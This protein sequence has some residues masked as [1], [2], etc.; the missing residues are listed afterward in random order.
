M[1]VTHLIAKKK[2]KIKKNSGKLQCGTRQKKF[3]FQIFKNTESLI[4]VILNETIWTNMLLLFSL[5]MCVNFLIHDLLCNSSTLPL[6]SVALSVWSLMLI[7]ACNSLSDPL[8]MGASQGLPVLAH[9]STVLL[10]LGWLFRGLLLEEC[11]PKR[12]SSSMS[13]SLDSLDNC[14]GCL[15]AVVVRILEGKKKNKRK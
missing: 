10:W 5:Y 8:L 15:E 2:K 12:L 1:N 14:T 7:K 6:T 9:R 13:L 3:Y 4:F 11:G